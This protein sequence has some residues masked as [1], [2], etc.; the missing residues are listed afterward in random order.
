MG[1]R[2]PIL[3]PNGHPNPSQRQQKGFGKTQ[4]FKNFH[5]PQNSPKKKKQREGVQK[6]IKLSK[7]LRCAKQ[8]LQQQFWGF[9]GAHGSGYMGLIATMWVPIGDRVPL[10]SPNDQ[11]KPS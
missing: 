5:V 9:Q 11:S 7:I 3:S 1:A 4:T 10:L 6:K 8:P 2:V